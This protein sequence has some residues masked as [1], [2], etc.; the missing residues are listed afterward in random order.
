MKMENKYY[1]VLHS[2]IQVLHGIREI[3]VLKIMVEKEGDDE[4][5]SSVGA[6]GKVSTGQNTIYNPGDRKV[7]GNSTPRFRFGLKW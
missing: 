6:D 5:R 2:Q 3:F 1:K 7:I 4:H